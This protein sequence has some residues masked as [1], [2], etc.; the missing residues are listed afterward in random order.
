MCTLFFSLKGNV[1]A[2]S[3]LRLAHLEKREIKLKKEG[4]GF[5]EQ[6]KPTLGKERNLFHWELFVL[7]KVSQKK[8]KE[9]LQRSEY[10]KRH[11][12]A[13]R[14]FLRIPKTVTINKLGEDESTNVQMNLIDGR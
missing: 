9:T 3:P 12:Q 11:I 2:L 6:L 14:S 5:S 8:I 7:E 13:W 4:L 10:H 1:T